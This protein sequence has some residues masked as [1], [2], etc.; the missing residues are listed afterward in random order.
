MEQVLE[1]EHAVQEKIEILIVYNGVTKPL[2]VNPH[3]Q[4]T[5][6]I[7]R[8][9]HLFGITQNAHLLSLFKENGAEIPDNQSVA[10]AGINPGELLALRPSAVKGG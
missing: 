4:I 6:V 5:A 10:A 9:V 8:A 3:E 7:Q 1:R 2:T